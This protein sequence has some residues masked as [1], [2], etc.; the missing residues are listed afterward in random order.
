MKG[1][2]LDRSASVPASKTCETIFV[3]F[4]FQEFVRDVSRNYGPF[5]K[6]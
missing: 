6:E 5:I 1:T 2:K 3:D 4:I